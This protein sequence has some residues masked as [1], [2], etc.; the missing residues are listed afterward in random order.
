M[1]EMMAL[2]DEGVIGSIQHLSTFCI[3]QLEH[4]MSSFSKGVHTGK[5][6]ITFDNPAA[7]LKVDSNDKYPSCI[8]RL[9]PIR[10]HDQSLEPS[11]TQL[12]RIYLS[13]VWAVSDAASR[14]G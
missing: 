14:Y 2:M 1:A 10:S 12:L 8:S 9:T 11:L 13:V 5:F 4:A 7:E 6:V 3:S